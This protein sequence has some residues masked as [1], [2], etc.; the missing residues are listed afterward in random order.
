M[1]RH[2]SW[3]TIATIEVIKCVCPSSLGCSLLL[4]LLLSSPRAVLRLRLLAL[5]RF[6]RLAYQ[7]IPNRQAMEMRPEDDPPRPP[8]SHAHLADQVRF[9][10]CGCLWLF[11]LDDDFRYTP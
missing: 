10:L 5:Q 7:R 11:A 2:L 3:V 1:R 9:L 4:F 8:H 6:T